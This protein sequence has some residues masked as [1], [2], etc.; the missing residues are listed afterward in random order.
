[1]ADFYSIAEILNSVFSGNTI[2]TFNTSA[3]V[4]NAVYSSG[5]TSL[6][7][8]ISSDLKIPLSKSLYFGNENTD[9]SWRI[10][11]V[12]DDLEIQKRVAGTW[13]LKTEISGS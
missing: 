13:V 1:M 11:V 12:G 9:G 4:L 7:I 8:S 5:S 3:D 2:S 6:N 10:L